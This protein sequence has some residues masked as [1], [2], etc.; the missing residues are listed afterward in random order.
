MS[1]NRNESTS[2]CDSNASIHHDQPFGKIPLKLVQSGIISELNCS[3]LKVFVA[4]SGYINGKTWS[5]YPSVK[6]L[7]DNAGVSVRTVQRATSNLEAK[8]I[9]FITPSAGRN[10]TNIYTISPEYTKL[11][12]TVS[13]SAPMTPIVSPVQELGGDKKTYQGCQ[14]TTGGVT[15]LA[16]GG[17]TQG[18]ILTDE[19]IKHSNSNA[20][21]NNIS[22]SLKA[23]SSNQ[24]AH[25]SPDQ[26]DKIYT[27]LSEVGISDP[28]R[29]RLLA[30]PGISQNIVC[31]EISKGK[32]GSKGNGAIINNILARAEANV[33]NQERQAQIDKQKQEERMVYEQ[34][35]EEAAKVQAEIDSIIP[36][37]NDSQLKKYKD[38]VCNSDSIDESTKKWYKESDPRKHRFLQAEIVAVY[39]ADQEAK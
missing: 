11:N 39:K 29:A 36:T 33:L 24:S 20:D 4:I 8:G 26:A 9:L 12:N 32:S 14:N 22:N 18:V 35:R 28:T 27:M 2:T 3:E 25:L 17:D 7:A 31:C 13:G 19:Q 30:T 6:T 37:L 5:C 1:N 34:E 15:E 23:G 38:Q 16:I 21:A 10:F